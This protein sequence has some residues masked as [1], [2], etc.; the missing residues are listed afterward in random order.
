[1]MSRIWSIVALLMAWVIGVS[2]SY[3][4]IAL[5]TD[6]NSH[7]VQ[8]F[9]VS[10]LL[11][12]MIGVTSFTSLYPFFESL[13]LQRDRWK[14][15]WIYWLA[16]LVLARFVYKVLAISLSFQNLLPTDRFILTY[17]LIS[18]FL[19]ACVLAPFGIWVVVNRFNSGDW[20][21]RWV[22]FS[23]RYVRGL[24]L[25]AL[26]FIIY[27]VLAL[28][29]NRQEFDTNNVFFAADTTSWNQRLTD[30]T[31]YLMGMRAV[32]PLA[33]LLMRPLVSIVSI[34]FDI[35]RFLAALST[36]AAIGSISVFL[37]YFFLARMSENDTYAFLFA[38]LFGISTTHLL[39]NAI[40]ES[41]VFS[42]FFLIAFFVL[43]QNKKVNPPILILSGIAVFG[44]TISNFFQSL[45]GFFLR[46]GIRRTFLYAAL[47]VGVGVLLTL[48]NRDFYPNSDPFYAPGNL[49]NES[50]FLING[51][52]VNQWVERTKLI[53]SDMFLFSIVAPKPF[54]RTYHRDDNSGY[55]KFDFMQGPRVSKF[56]GLGKIAVWLWLGILIAGIFVFIRSWVS[57]GNSE[58]NR[59]NLAFICCLGFN[60]VLHLFY[61][62][63]PFL[64]AADWTYAMILFTA[65]AWHQFAGN[66][67][68]HLVL[69]ML[70]A[71]L[72]LNNLSFL[73][74]LMSGLS[75][76][77]P[78]STW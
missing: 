77:I 3:F 10:L 47:V 72:T 36:V 4:F 1:M 42:A 65:L 55:P 6:I 62:F 13:A 40:I 12:L 69:L 48:V 26:F 76:F 15:D 28:V 61:G 56:V 7:P 41:Y 11:M 24:L 20:S 19:I 31:G 54:V 39:F 44:I 46:S 33:F 38:T 35:D 75:P 18:P 17:N 51:G 49:T 32:H 14:A 73:H 29:F 63:E 34:I 70:I 16:F 21:S 66:K 68:M 22:A 78:G 57:K 23:Q 64:Y 5:S 8:M 67:I 9:G 43:L 58:V 60:F 74:F 53:G 27:F 71:L 52:S 25:A 45:I 30:E 37:F 2:I 50:R 59:I